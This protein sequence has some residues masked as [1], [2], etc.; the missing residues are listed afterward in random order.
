[1]SISTEESA[2]NYLE[3]MLAILDIDAQVYEENIDESTTCLRIDCKASDAKL[4]IGRKGQTL[5]ALQ[6]LLRQMCR[7][8]NKIEQPHFMLDVLN[9]R[10][11]RREQ[12]VDQAK[13]GA[14]A[15]LNGETEEFELQPMSAFERRVVHKYLQE[16]FPE[17]SSDSRGQGEDRHI[18]I[19]YVGLSEEEREYGEVEEEESFVAAEKEGDD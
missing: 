19:S 16:H 7:G 8:P 3:K 6:F 1:M 15:V 2:K 14:V 11:R 10:Q 9:Y 13:E 17:L 12:I 4:L 5:E 18:V